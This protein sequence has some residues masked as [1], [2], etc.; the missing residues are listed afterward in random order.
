MI[1][2]GASGDAV[3]CLERAGAIVQAGM[4]DAGVVSRLMR[5]DAVFLVHDY[6]AMAGKAAGVVEG[7]G[8]SDDARA[9]DEEVGLAIG[10]KEVPSGTHHYKE[11]SAQAM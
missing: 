9:D 1:H 7:G 5:S 10:H 8:E 4:D 6:K 3:A 2:G 11:G